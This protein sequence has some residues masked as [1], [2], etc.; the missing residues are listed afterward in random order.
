MIEVSISQRGMVDFQ[1]IIRCRKE[2]RFRAHCL[3][4]RLTY[5]NK[6]QYTRTLFSLVHDD[7]SLPTP[8]VTKGSVS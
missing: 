3:A 8:S 2:K 1:I 7:A 5:N 6:S 4:M